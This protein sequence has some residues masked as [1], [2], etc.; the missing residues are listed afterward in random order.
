MRKLSLVVLVGVKLCGQPGYTA[1][2]LVSAATGLGGCLA[3]N[4]LVSLYGRNLQTPGS[5]ATHV[6]VNR[7]QAPV[8]HASPGQLNFLIPGQL[9][10]GVVNF[11]VAVGGV[12]GPVVPV[13]LAPVCPGFFSSN[14]FV[15]AAHVDGRPVTPGL[16]ARA[17]MVISLYGT[18]FGRTVNALDEQGIPV[19]ADPLLA[20][21]ELQIEMGGE[22][23]PASRVLYAGLAPGFAGLYQF[24]VM[25]PENTGPD[26]VVRARSS[27]VWSVGVR[28][29]VEQPVPFSA[30][31]VK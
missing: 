13:T 24:N 9:R 29:A 4:M 25:V 22:P 27:G 14:G 18:A 31:I 5:F 10:P 15:A 19:Q 16:P 7:E 6:F 1:D 2:G 20:W 17:G 11:S 12:T 28:L 21:H 23:L 8:L 3:P 26:P 30:R